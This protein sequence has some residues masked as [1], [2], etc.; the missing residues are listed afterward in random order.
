LQ[1]TELMTKDQN[2]KLKRRSLAKES[3]ESRR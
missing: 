1:N 2:L 3:R